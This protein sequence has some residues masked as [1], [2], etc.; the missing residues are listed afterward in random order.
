MD[1]E[2]QGKRVL[3]TGASRGLGSAIVDQFTSEGACVAGC[4]RNPVGAEDAHLAKCYHI[5]GDVTDLSSAQKI[6]ESAV[7]HLGGLDIVICNVGS[8]KSVPPLQETP[9]DWERSI[10]V[11]L[12]STTNMVTC[13]LP[14]LK[15][16][17]GTIICVS[18]ICG[19]ETIPGAPLT[20]SASKSALNSFISGASRTL[21]ADKIR[22]CGLA[23]GNIM[24]DGSTWDLKMKADPSE[25]QRIVS[26]TVPM[27]DFAT[28][29][30]MAK[31]IVI[32]ASPISKFSTGSVYVVDG[33]QTR[34][35]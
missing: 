21:A 8:G 3:V 32:L 7:A 16:S 23:P 26:E 10:A 1:L 15:S 13:A 34:S 29:T 35:W 31:H 27:N 17:S 18:S 22:I 6:V 12:Y 19:V 14:F 25:T 5:E 30:G 24:F 20:Y 2:L 9:E 28:A 33:G 11:N 4:S